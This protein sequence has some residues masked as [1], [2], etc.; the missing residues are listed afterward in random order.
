MPLLEKLVVEYG[1]QF[2][3]ARLNADEQQALAGQLGARSLPT[4]LLL[5]DGQPVDGFTGAQ[6][7]STIRELL[8]KYLPKPWDIQLAQAREHIARGD[9]KQALPLLRLAYPD[10][11]QRADIALELTHVLLELNRATDAEKILEAIPM[12]EQDARYQQLQ[13]QLELKQQSAH[14]PEIQALR[15]QLNEQPDNLALAYQ[16]AIQFSQNEHPAEALALLWNILQN[17]RDFQDGAAKKALLDIITSLGSGDPLAT[18]YQRKLF[19]L[20]Y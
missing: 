5:K 9:F 15:S 2:L 1:G 6:P 14:T 4:V 13:A 10:S 11:R 12:V 17:D 3:L 8:D 16:L 7:E 19:G 18:E 20:L